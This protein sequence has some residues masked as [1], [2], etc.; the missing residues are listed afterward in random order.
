[1]QEDHR[2]LEASLN[3]IISVMALCFKTRD[4]IFVTIHTPYL[5]F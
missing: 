3:Y 4:N 2:E 5:T 1:M